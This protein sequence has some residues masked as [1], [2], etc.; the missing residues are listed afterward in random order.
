[1]DENNDE[2]T[3]STD[4]RFE[5]EV[6]Q[7]TMQLQRIQAEIN[8]MLVD[9]RLHAGSTNVLD[10]AR[11]IQIER[12]LQSL[13]NEQTLIENPR[14]VNLTPFGTGSPDASTVS[15]A[16]VPGPIL[17][18]SGSGLFMS[19]PPNTDTYITLDTTDPPEVVD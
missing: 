8:A 10:Q 16:P 4:A 6:R 3:D 2:I 9:A 14:F 15:T 12:A 11:A 7:E 19:T 18:S 5:F 17:P 1:M 13:R